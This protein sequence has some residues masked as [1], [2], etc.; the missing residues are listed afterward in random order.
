MKRDSGESV[1]VCV[2][3]YGGLVGSKDQGPPPVR[4]VPLSPPR[5]LRGSVAY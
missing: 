3:V 1:C 2:C 5:S 4:A